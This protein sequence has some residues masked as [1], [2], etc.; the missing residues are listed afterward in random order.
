MKTIEGSEVIEALQWRYATKQFDTSRKIPADQWARLEQALV[1]SPSSA[2]LQPWA[3]VVVENPAV[4]EELKGASYGQAQITDASHLVVFA[5][6]TD[7][8]QADIDAYF[9]RIA[10]VRN[11]PAEALAPFRGMVEG[12]VLS[13]EPADKAAW[14]ARQPYIALGMFLTTAALMGID[15]CPMEGFSPPDYDRIL[16]LTEKGLTAVAVATVGYRSS[17]DKYAELPKV[18]FPAEQVIL[19]V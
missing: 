13:R 19:H 15:A 3:F 18:R 17:E 7:Y 4:R 10:A 5:A 11:A 12:S 9:D 16:G 8:T 14:L 1:L 2:G 6:K